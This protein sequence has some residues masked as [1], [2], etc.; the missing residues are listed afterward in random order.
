MFRRVNDIRNQ[1]EETNYFSSLNGYLTSLQTMNPSM[2]QSVFSKSKERFLM[3]IPSSRT[4]VE[5]IQIQKTKEQTRNS[6]LLTRI[7]YRY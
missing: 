5:V 2:E 3:G 6:I 7:T 4:S 1:L